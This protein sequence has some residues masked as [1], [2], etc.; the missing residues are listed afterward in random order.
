MNKTSWIFVAVTVLVCLC[1]GFFF[2][3]PNIT[4]TWK[5]HKETQTAKSDLDQVAKKK[6]I[7][8]ALANNPQLGSLYDIASKYIPES[9]NSSELIIGLSAMASE[10]NLGV[11]QLTFN[12]AT[13]AAA[14]TT[15]TNTAAPDTTDA[16]TGTK[17]I[18]FDMTVSGTFPNFLNFLKST[19]TSSRLIMVQVT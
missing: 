2:T 11:D 17:E 14:A 15:A 13:G 10:S 9:D 18:T 1:I 4:S 19:E 6:E 5:I 3:R 16:N 8:T 7:L 12:T